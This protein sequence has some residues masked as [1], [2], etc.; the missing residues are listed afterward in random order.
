[1]FLEHLLRFCSSIGQFFSFFY[2]KPL[3]VPIL[4]NKE[5][6]AIPVLVSTHKQKEVGFT[7]HEEL[8]ENPSK[9]ANQPK[10]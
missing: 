8:V 9:I 3:Q 5:I 1:V 2:E 7:T 4:I 10:P 6:R